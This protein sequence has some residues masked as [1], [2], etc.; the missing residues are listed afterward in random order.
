MYI[1]VCS[2]FCYLILFLKID[3]LSL[4]FNLGN[5]FIIFLDVIDVVCLRKI[6]KSDVIKFFQVY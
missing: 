4:V 1:V 6:N 3:Q 2:F 5:L